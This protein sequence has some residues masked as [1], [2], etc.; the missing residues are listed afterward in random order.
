MKSPFERIKFSLKLKIGL[1]FVLLVIVMMGVVTYIFSIREAN[2]R[3]EQV[4][5]RMERLANNIATIRSVETG[6]WGVY[7]TYIDNQIRLNPDIVY[8]AIF[9]ENS[10][11][12]T[13]ALNPDWIDL[14]DQPHLTRA[15]EMHIINQ[16]E[17]RQIA[18]ESQRDLESKS[19]NIII[20]NQNLGTVKVGFSL[21]DL[22]DSMRNNLR[23]NFTLAILFIFAAIIVSFLISSRIINPLEKLTSAMLEISRGDFNQRVDIKSN[24]EIG[25]LAATFNFMSKGL[26]EKELLEKFSRDLG[27]TVEL[28]KAARL[29]T[30]QITQ[31]LEAKQGFLF[32]KDKTKEYGFRLFYSYPGL[33]KNDTVFVLGSELYESVMCLQAPASFNDLCNDMSQF[34]KL[35][36][37]IRVSDDNI[38]ISSIIIKQELAGLFFLILKKEPN[39]LNI[40]DRHFLQT[41]IGQGA[42]ALESALLYEELT[43]QKQLK[44]ELEIAHAVQQSLLPQENPKMPGVNISGVCIPAADVGG[45]YYDYFYIDRHTIGIAIADVAGKGISAA[46]YMAVVKGMMLSLAPIIS[47]PK[48]LLSVLNKK[49]FGKMDRK[50]FITMIYAVLDVRHQ[51]LRFARAGHNAL[52]MKRK[53]DSQSHFL[54]PKGL[55]LG[56]VNGQLFD[57]NLEEEKIKYQTGDT[58]L[59]Y[60]DGIP[61]A[62]NR[63]REEFSEERLLEVVSNSSASGCELIREQITNAVN[64]FVQDAP[65]HDDITMIC[66]ATNGE[67]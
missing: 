9:D 2:L 45:D 48:R 12:K 18:A 53:V 23:W 30:K 3:V 41:L 10:L 1:L 6:D 21:V 46:F 65:Q 67:A 17:Q 28:N 36:E 15:E 57:K 60:T 13:Y 54:E 59:F 64:G 47:S 11:L 31:A 44:R 39:K 24:D 35:Q 7:E 19:V 27:F 32:I 49:L 4:K 66:V 62:M 38:L 42:F 37:I 40:N 63:H 61:E 29:I 26:Q 52:I 5:L 43:Q 8:I 14:G 20:G 56:L 58:F 16:L 33:L 25:S 34:R 51:T 55:G 50:L 22:N